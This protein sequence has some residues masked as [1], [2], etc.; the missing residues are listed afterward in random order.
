MSV[1]EGWTHVLTQMLAKQRVYRQILRTNR[2]DF[3]WLLQK[4][5]KT[6]TLDSTV[7]VALGFPS[8][9]LTIVAL[10][11]VFRVTYTLQLL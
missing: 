10:V 2:S 5:T 1:F 4:E 8:S 6:A 11:F 9:G 7:N 3:R